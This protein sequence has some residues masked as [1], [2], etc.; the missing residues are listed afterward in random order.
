[1]SPAPHDDEDERALRGR[2]TCLLNA[3]GL[4]AARSDLDLYVRVFPE[5][6]F[7]RSARALLRK[8]GR[9]P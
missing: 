4:D 9:S 7:A 6:P 3:E 2:A 5:Q 1:L 8:S